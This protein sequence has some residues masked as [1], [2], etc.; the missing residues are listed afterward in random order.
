MKTRILSGLIVLV[1]VV[2][3]FAQPEPEFEKGSVVVISANVTAQEVQRDVLEI[4]RTNATRIKRVDLE[5]EKA[6]LQGN[7]ATAEA[8][9][10]EIDKFLAVYE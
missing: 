2:A 8:R 5:R 6:H 9:I 1:C 4:K 10:A 3:C 7:I